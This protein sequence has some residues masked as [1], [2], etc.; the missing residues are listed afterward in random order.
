MLATHRIKGLWL[1]RASGLGC[2][3]IVKCE[4]EHDLGLGHRDDEAKTRPE[5]FKKLKRGA[6]TLLRLRF[7]LKRT[8]E[9]WETQREIGMLLYPER[10]NAASSRDGSTGGFGR[11]AS[12]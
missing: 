12:D 3:S 10:R 1:R 11:R 6:E 5:N 2:R 9:L 8:R 4:V 7:C